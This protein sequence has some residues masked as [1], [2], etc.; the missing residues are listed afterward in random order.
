MVNTST[1]TYTKTDIRKVFENFQADLLMLALR[2]QAMEKY[3]V[4]D[5]AHDIL[6]M[7]KNGCLK[8]IHIQLYNY[9][10]QLIKVHKY[11]V[12][13]NSSSASQRP[14]E[15]KWPCLPNGELCIIVEPSC[16][17]KLEELKQSGQLEISWGPSFLSTDYSGMRNENVR[18]YSS[19]NYGLQRNTFVNL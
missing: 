4:N 19:N 11:S 7:T 16:H 8:Y 5:Y 3:L 12:T 9:Y 18:F 15:N 1:Q 6:L 13:E 17:Q 2:T 10:G 14:G